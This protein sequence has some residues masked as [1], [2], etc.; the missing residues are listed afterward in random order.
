MN[1]RELVSLK[2]FDPVINLSW[3]GNINEQERLLSN[4]IMTENLA[5]IFVN[6]LE[7]I[8]LTRSEGRRE[9]LGG[10]IDLTVTKRSHILSGQYG[11]GK[12][13]FLLMLNVVLEMKNTSLANKII[14]RFSEY[15]ELQYQ[16]KHIRENK[17]YFLVRIN[18]E[19]EN[20]KE[21]KD[22]IQSEVINA[23]EKEFGEVNISS[24]YKKTL[25]MFQEVYDRNRNRMDEILSKYGYSKDDIIASLSNYRKDGII[26]SEAVIKETTGFTPKI[27]L[28][29]LEDFLKDVSEILKS[30]GYKE[31]VIVFDEFSAYLTTSIEDRRINKDLG[32]IQNLAQLSVHSSNV[33]ISFIG[34]THKDLTEMIGNAGVSKKEELDKV[35]GRFRVHQLTYGQEEEL[36]KNTLS[37]NKSGFSKYKEEYREMFEELE[38][39]YGRSMEDFYPLHP[40]TIMYL[41]PMTK[42]YAQGVRTAFG[43]FE[44]K[45]RNEYF[46]QEVIKDGKLNLVTV[47]DLY[48]Y[49]EGDIEDKKR[50]LYE[51][52][53]QVR[54]YVKEDKNLVDFSKA[55]AVAYSSSLTVSG[56]I[57]ELSAKNLMH[58]YLMESEEEVEKKMN[59]LVSDDHINI[60]KNNNK[61]RLS[62]NN[63]GI[64]IDSLV[65]KEKENINPNMMRDKILYKSQDRIFIKNS[66]NLKYNMGLYPMD[67][68]LEGSIYSL[69]ELRKIKFESNFSTDKDGKIIFIIPRFE[70]NYDE[71]NLASEYLE[72]MKSLDRNICLAI[73]KDIVFDGDALKEYGA[74][75]KVERDERIAKDDELKRIVVS[76][77]RKLEDKIRNKY[78]RKFCNLK[79]FTFIFSEGKRRIDLRQD[80]ALYK[81]ILYSHYKKF[82][83]EI[84]VE[85]FNSRNP[86]NKLIKLFLD[87]GS[88]EITKKDKTSEEAKN[89]YATLKPLDLVKITEHVNTEKVEFQSP[90]GEISILS[91]EIMDIVE[92][93]ENSLSL[94]EKYKTLTNA[95]YGLSTQLVDLYFFISNKLGRTYI[96]NIKTGRP[97]SLDSNNIKLLSEK[98]DEYQLK[99]NTVV[100]ITEQLKAVWVSFNKIKGVRTS[101]NKVK[102]NGKNDFN[103]PLTLGKEMKDI[104]DKLLDQEHTLATYGINT[105]KLKTLTNKLKVISLKYKAEELFECVEKIVDIFRKAT[106][107]EN[108]DELDKFILNLNSIMEKDTISKI[109][110]VRQNLTNLGYKIKDLEKYS[111]FKEEL[112]IQQNG[113]K[114]YLEDFLNMELLNRLYEATQKLMNSYIEEFKKKHDNFYVEYDKQRNDLLVFTRDK[115]ECIKSLESLNFGNIASMKEFFLEIEKFEICD[116]VMG[117]ETIQCVCEYDELKKLENAVS[118]L[119]DKFKKNKHQILGVFERYVEEMENLRN[120]LGHSENYRRLVFALRDIQNGDAEKTSEIGRLVESAS[121]EINQYLGGIE[122]QSVKTVDFEELSKNLV[123]E[124]LSIGKK[125]VD[126]EEF[127]L[128]FNQ[129]IND[130][131]AREYKSIKLT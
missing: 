128:K 9:K 86:L 46:N 102:V 75:L 125:N 40:A 28:D 78:L 71:E 97:L 26:K 22:I 85:N 59:P 60:I 74:L 33:E 63:S 111:D 61:Y 65:R 37:L 116:C 36:L 105:G 66:Y 104:Y 100:D 17:K 101:G 25:S 18:G 41:E 2:S 20:E 39:E 1:I 44:K 82:P 49:F 110:Q 57:T 27:E 73:P 35:L 117:E 70:E 19:N 81:E 11:T 91:K 94:E 58:M 48:D 124:M 76:R 30:K 3:A 23:L 120:G 123:Q 88:T 4:Y 129:V 29:K 127:I 68:A 56:A 64:D 43:F 107:K 114:D 12:S 112:K 83:H 106:F 93:T 109:S 115:V 84:K 32:Q 99:K 45:V 131:K 96:E 13:Y 108:L 79:N 15:P 21:F 5:E 118:E 7:S 126:F 62:V 14:E 87:G 55:L 34:S 52:L 90:R 24:V 130:Y 50:K 38:E 67:R 122:I 121:D 47:S 51:T 42:L 95:P 31:M 89:I 80:K 16:L 119:E 53:N 6:M 103:V 77:R 72:K 10:D 92:A 98:S 8:T 69:E 54:N 113:Y